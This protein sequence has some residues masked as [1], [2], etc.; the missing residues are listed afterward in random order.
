[1]GKTEVAKAEA[2]GTLGGRLQALRTRHGLSLR[3]LSAQSGMSYEQISRLES[4]RN[5]PQKRTI[6]N[7]SRTFRVDPVDL[8][9]YLSGRSAMPVGKNGPDMNLPDIVSWIESQEP[10][11]RVRVAKVLLALVPE[12]GD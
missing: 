6:Q 2:V 3:D 8:N 11:E 10:A 12:A 7:L 5:T 4:D 1:M 9:D